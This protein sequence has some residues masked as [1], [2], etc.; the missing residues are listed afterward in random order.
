MKRNKSQFFLLITFI[1]LSIAGRSYSQTDWSDYKIVAPQPF[2]FIMPQGDN[3]YHNAEP[4]ILVVQTVGAFD[5]Y[6]ITNGGFCETDCA[7]NPRNPLNFIICDNNVQ[8]RS[9]NYWTTDGGVSAWSLGTGLAG[10]QG[11]G[12][13]AFDS[14]GNAYL[15]ISNHG[16]RVF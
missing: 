12:V 9:G 1:F 16:S 8:L 10:N 3:F 7:V 4:N 5:N 11:D 6:K 2:K 14:A 15:A 13:V